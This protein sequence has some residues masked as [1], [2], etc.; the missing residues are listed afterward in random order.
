MFAR[1]EYIE[2]AEDSV[3]R[4]VVQSMCSDGA[5]DCQRWDVFGLQTLANPGELDGH[6]KHPLGVLPKSEF[7][8]GQNLIRRTDV[9]CIETTGHPRQQPMFFGRYQEPGPVVEAASGFGNLQGSASANAVSDA[10]GE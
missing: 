1:N 2:V 3:C 7:E 6:D 4:I 8:R 5:F 9:A 10:R